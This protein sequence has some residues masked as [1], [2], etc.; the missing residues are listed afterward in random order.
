MNIKTTSDTRNMSCKS[1]IKQRKHMVQINLNHI[2][3]RIP[4]SINALDRGVS[5]PLI[6]KFSHIPYKNY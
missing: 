2:L 6:R 3:S 1:F 5:H 4:H